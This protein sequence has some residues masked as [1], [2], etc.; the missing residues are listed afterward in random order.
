[1][2]NV[3]IFFP[4]SKDDPPLSYPYIISGQ[5]LNSPGILQKSL[6]NLNNI[7]S[8]AEYGESII[9]LPHNKTSY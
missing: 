8:N 6:V 4:L 3:Q 7:F 5:Y 2:D 9:Y 1:M